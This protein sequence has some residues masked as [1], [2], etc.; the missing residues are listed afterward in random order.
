[1]ADALVPYSAAPIEPIVTRAVRE[2]ELHET[3]PFE[4][5]LSV[6]DES[7]DK[8]YHGDWWVVARRLRYNKKSPYMPRVIK[9]GVARH[10]GVARKFAQVRQDRLWTHY[11]N[12]RN[13]RGLFDSPASWAADPSKYPMADLA[14]VDFTYMARRMFDGSIKDTFFHTSDYDS[15]A[16]EH[17]AKLVIQLLKLDLKA[18]HPAPTKLDADTPVIDL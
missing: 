15:A 6:V 12:L 17:L 9:F 11:Y 1:M 5:Q 18:P 2:L 10:L 4:R 13:D 16:K 7:L 14:G 8:Y 3:I